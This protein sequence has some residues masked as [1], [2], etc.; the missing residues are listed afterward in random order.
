[1]GCYKRSIGRFKIV[2]YVKNIQY[3]RYADSR[4]TIR[5]SSSFFTS[6]YNVEPTSETKC[7]KPEMHLKL[8]L[9]VCTCVGKLETGTASLVRL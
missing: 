2:L 3:P 7:N 5:I 6:D 8:I 1:M 4:Y 9:F